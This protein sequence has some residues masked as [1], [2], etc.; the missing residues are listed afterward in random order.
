[1][2]WFFN[3]CRHYRQSISLLAGGALPE[4]ERDAIKKH[5]TACADCRKYYEDLTAVSQ[6]LANWADNFASLEPTAAAK[7]RWAQ[8]IQA[9]GGARRSARA[10]NSTSPDGR[11]GFGV[12]GHVRALELADMSA[13]RKAATCPRTPKESGGAHGA[14]RPTWAFREWWRDV[15]W[16]CR[17]V[18]A[19]LAAV[20][21]LILAGN[22]A[23]REPSSAFA[24]KS[25]PAAREMIMA[26]K[27]QQMILSELLADHAAPREA[28]PQKVFSPKPR[29]KNDGVAAA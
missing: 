12:R 3:P 25:A 29:T 14:A 16:P 24:A 15:V 27:D 7:T 18:W 20:W 23:L 19:G 10:A 4:S 8:A 5:L 21:V 13:S 9:A 11:P 17:R 22:V 1:M 2:K 28:E 6:T 26:F